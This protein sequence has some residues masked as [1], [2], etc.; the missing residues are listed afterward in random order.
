M[1][2]MVA[3]HQSTLHQQPSTQAQSQ[4]QMQSQS[5]LQSQLQSQS[6]AQVQTQTQSQSGKTH[7]ITLNAPN[8]TST[9]SASASTSTS[10][11]MSASSSISTTSLPSGKATTTNAGTAATL[12]NR[13]IEDELKL[14]NIHIELHVLLWVG[15]LCADIDNEFF[16]QIL[17]ACGKVIEWKR[18][19]DTFG[20]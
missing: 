20:F 7:Q 4:V 8:V 12:P 11:S 1:A 19:K 2:S 13:R 10:T 14:L 15:H 16:L 5:Q 3:Q 18:M 6:Q 9:P 17:E